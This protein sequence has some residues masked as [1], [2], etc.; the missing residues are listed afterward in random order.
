MNRQLENEVMPSRIVIIGAGG[1]GREALDVYDACNAAGQGPFEVLGFLSDGLARGSTVSGKPIL[2]GIEWLAEHNDVLALCA[3]GDPVTRREVVQRASSLGARF[4]TAIHPSAKLT[5]WVELGTGTLI[6]AGCILTND[7][8]LGDHVHCNL[9]ST[10]SH[11]AVI[12]DYVTLAPGVHIA[13]NVTLEAG[14]NVGI[15]AV[16]IQARRVG[17][18]AV[19][20]AGAVVISDIPPDSVAVGVPAKVVRQREP[21]WHASD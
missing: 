13:G 1:H 17:A 4:H 18:G 8:R 21:P 15:G 5:R 2:G 6:T 10:I 12:E 16:I 7:V 20:G 14:C 9:A 11:D 19:I 3:I